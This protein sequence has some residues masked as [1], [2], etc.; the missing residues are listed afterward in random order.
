MNATKVLIGSIIFSVLL[1][2]TGFLISKLKFQREH[3]TDTETNYVMP[4]RSIPVVSTPPVAPPLVI[5]PNPT[6]HADNIVV[7]PKPKMTG[8]QDDP[9]LEAFLELVGQ[10][11][12]EYDESENEPTDVMKY[13]PDEMLKYLSDNYT[14]R[15]QHDF[16]MSDEFDDWVKYAFNPPQITPPDPSDC[17]EQNPDDPFAFSACMEE[18]FRLAIAPY[19]KEFEEAMTGVMNFLK[20]LDPQVF[21]YSVNDVSASIIPVNK[22]SEALIRRPQ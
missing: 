16:L 18:G 15:E 13:T 10:I 17:R 20:Q 2:P 3:K 4:K 1:I 21:T 22:P 19:R 6:P 9:E 5:N 8:P 12:F 7:E 11:D 14:P